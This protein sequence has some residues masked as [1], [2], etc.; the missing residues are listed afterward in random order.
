MMPI[1]KISGV[2]TIT[3]KVDIEADSAEEALELFDSDND[4]LWYGVHIKIDWKI[5]DE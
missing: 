5:A 2:E 4:E 3:F 1:F